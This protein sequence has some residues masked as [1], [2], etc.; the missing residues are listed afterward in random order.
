MHPK[1]DMLRAFVDQELSEKQIR[2]LN[3]HFRRCSEC[4][5]RMDAIRLRAGAVRTSFDALAPGDRDAPRSPVSAYRT[6]SAKQKEPEMT[7]FT[8]RPF[9]VVLGVVAVLAI[10]LSITPVR[11]WASSLL[12]L[13]RVQQVTVISFDPMAARQ[14][15]D[16]LAGNEQ[17]LEQLLNDNLEIIEQGEMKA[18]NSSDE[19]AAITGYTPRLPTTDQPGQF[20]VKPATQ[21]NLTIDQP[22]MQAIVDAA[23]VDMEIPV[24][25]DGGVVRFDMPSAV[26]AVYGDCPTSTD[27]MS[28]APGCTGL[29]QLPSPSVNAP[30]GFDVQKIGQAMLQFLGY[31]PQEALRLSERID[32]ATTLILPIPQGEGITYRDVTADGVPATLLTN[33]DRQQYALVWVKDGMLYVL[34]GQGGLEEA[35]TIVSTLQ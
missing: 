14:G 25:V 31:S 19:A 9:W 33:D 3:E 6:F 13:F 20:F 26:V 1:D 22:V 35:Q 21:A 32:W 28:F 18:L 12:G 5:G 4:A 34:H 2:L 8:R 30:E 15:S 16:R 24:A 7:I 27:P 29:I 23:G 11:T 10:A 17:M